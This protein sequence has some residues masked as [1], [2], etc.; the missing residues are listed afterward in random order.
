MS[1]PSN[2][3]RTGV[4][5]ERAL[6]TVMSDLRIATTTSGQARRIAEKLY[7]DGYIIVPHPYKPPA[8]RGGAR[9]QIARANKEALR[10]A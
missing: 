2:R 1:G 4:P 6:A 9:A 5:A 3:S 8:G 7:L 10:D